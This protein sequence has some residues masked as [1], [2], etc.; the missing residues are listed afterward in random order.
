MHNVGSYSAARKAQRMI[1]PATPHRY[2]NHA[3][4][5]ERLRARLQDITDLVETLSASTLTLLLA[6]KPLA[7]E[8]LQEVVIKEAALRWIARVAAASIGKVRDRLWK[9]IEK[10]LD[11]LEPSV[12]LLERMDVAWPANQTLEFG[13]ELGHIT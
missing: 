6:E 9:D 12:S 4:Y 11:D 5:E 8:M 2:L 7:R 1:P 10:A 13:E 3:Q